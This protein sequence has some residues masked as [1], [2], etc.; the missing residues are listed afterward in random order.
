M[1]WQTP[2][3]GAIFDVDGTLI[4]SVDYHATAWVEAL[5]DYGHVVP[6]E[7]VRKQIGKGG[8]QLM[9]EFLSRQELA[10]YG[11]DLEA[12][13]G[14]ILKERYLPL[15]TAFPGVRD[16]F[17]RLIA[18]GRQVALASSAKE[19]ELT[20]YKKVANIY[21]LIDAET[22]SDDAER[23]KPHPD[24]FQA[25]LER[26]PDLNPAR[27]IVIGDTPWDAEAASKVGL[28]MI[29]LMC[30]GW[31]EDELRRYGCIA[32]YKD[33]AD[34]LAQYDRSPLGIKPGQS[35]AGP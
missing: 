15:M 21:D 11:G 28:R 35:L 33:P 31:A 5:R 22:S 30:G 7:Q 8:D 24:I 4:D 29:G 6:F 26:L 1:E 18:D 25:V 13:R 2:I 23:S 27:A 12:H 9:P 14:R 19:D 10:A 3:E 32:V 20:H 34:L 17:Q 16:L